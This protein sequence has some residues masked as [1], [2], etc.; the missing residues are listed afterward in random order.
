MSDEKRFQCVKRML[1]LFHA[2]V[3]TVFVQ[4]FHETDSSNPLRED[5]MDGFK[6]ANST[7]LYDKHFLDSDIMKNSDRLSLRQGAVPSLNLNGSEMPKS[8]LNSPTK[9]QLMPSSASA[10]LFF[11]SIFV[12]VLTRTDFSYVNS[13][14]YIY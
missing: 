6:V 7:F 12:S 2:V 11:S 5:I 13:V 3:K 4:T 14:L 8:S 9:G 10:S 1:P